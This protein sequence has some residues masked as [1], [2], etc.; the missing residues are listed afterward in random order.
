MIQKPSWDVSLEGDMVAE[1]F[2]SIPA[3]SLLKPNEENRLY[4]PEFLSTEWWID[5]DSFERAY[6]TALVASDQDNKQV[7]EIVD[8]AIAEM[9]I[10]D[11][12]VKGCDVLYDKLYKAKHGFASSGAVDKE[13]ES[14]VARM[15]NG[16]K[17]E[18]VCP[19]VHS[20]KNG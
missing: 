2:C 17:F 15:M 14:W 13:V 1:G 12:L 11:N 16:E 3:E 10:I 19:L 5:T 7:M 9:R 4:W 8:L 6:K 18:D 20:K